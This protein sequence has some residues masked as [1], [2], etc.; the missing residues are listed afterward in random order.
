[1]LIFASSSDDE[2]TLA[3]EVTLADEDL[4]VLDD[5][6]S[7]DV[8]PPNGSIMSM[9]PTYNAANNVALEDSP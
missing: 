2:F 4:S 6:V 8:L 3:D 1:M 9:L 5:M 7:V